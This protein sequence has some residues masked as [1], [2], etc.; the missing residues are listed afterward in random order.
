MQTRS[1]IDSAAANAQQ[2]PQPAWSRTSETEAHTLPHCSRESN[3]SGSE[4]T[5]SGAGGNLIGKVMFEV[6]SPHKRATS[7]CWAPRNLDEGSARKGLLW[8]W[9]ISRMRVA[10]ITGISSAKP[11]G[12]A[13][14]RTA[15]H[16]PDIRIVVVFVWVDTNPLSPFVYTTRTLSGAQ[17]EHE[18]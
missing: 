6:R 16:Q 18:F 7:R 5:T 10:V 15:A 17:S 4:L 3:D 8:S 11:V 12:K 2:P 14:R 13:A 1:V 9:L